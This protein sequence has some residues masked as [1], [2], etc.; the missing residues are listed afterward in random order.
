MSYPKPFPTGFPLLRDTC[1]CVQATKAF[2]ID[3][4]Y[5]NIPED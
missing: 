5:L 2:A 4:M 1:T 3:V